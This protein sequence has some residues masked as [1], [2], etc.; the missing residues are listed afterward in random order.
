MKAWC[1]QQQ[2]VS[3]EEYLGAQFNY[4]LAGWL[5]VQ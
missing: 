4:D 5:A 1:V 3:R 2:R